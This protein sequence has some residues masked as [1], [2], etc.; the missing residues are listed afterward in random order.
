M[1]VHAAANKRHLRNNP[2]QLVF[3]ELCSAHCYNSQVCPPP[4]H[5]RE[6]KLTWSMIKAAASSTGVVGDNRQGVQKAPASFPGPAIRTRT[7]SPSSRPVHWGSG[8]TRRACC[9]GCFPGCRLIVL[10]KAV[11]LQRHVPCLFSVGTPQ[12]QRRHRPR[13][14]P[15]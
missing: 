14:A 1:L 4:S 7:R 5:I 9:P 12:Q 2:C 10:P 8:N 15:Q 13:R 6:V 11:L 3:A